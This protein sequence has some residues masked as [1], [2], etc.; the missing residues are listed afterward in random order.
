M[1]FKVFKFGGA[2]IKNA[3]AIK[4][5]ANIIQECANEKLMIVVSAMDKTTN[6]LE[7]VVDDAFYTNQDFTKK[8]DDI[9]NFHLQIIDDLINENKEETL[10]E[11]N[12][13]FNEL[14]LSCAYKHN[15]NYDKFYDQIVSFGELISTTIIYNY[16]KTRFNIYY[17]DARDFIITDAR[18]RDAAV[19]WEN[20]KLNVENNLI[21]KFEKYD[22]VISQGF[23][24]GNIDK[25]T[26]T[27]GR[28]GSDFSA[29]IFSY[30]L[31]AESLTVWK[32][33]D[34]LLNADPKYFENTEL[35]ENIS[36]RETIELA[37][38]GAKIIHPKTIQPLQNKSIPLYVKS[39]L[40]KNSKGSIINANERND[41]KIPSYIF[42]KN[43]VLI[44]ITPR[45]LSFVDESN[46]A[47]IFERLAYYSL[48][49]NL[50]QNSAI[51]FSIC[52]D[53]KEDKIAEFILDLS[54]EFEIRYNENLELITIRHYND[55]IIERMTKE[56]KIFLEQKS[57]ATVQYL[58]K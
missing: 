42:K 49:V 23:I 21:P 9:K 41:G 20:C 1:D 55:E 7:S 29:A 40:N 51:S 34:G 4:N 10:K 39:F 37:F 56:R 3:D 33:V 43:Q 14:S 48:K 27:L 45:N 38:Y 36:Y 22:F 24:G 54:D 35:I 19:I 31:D 15:N 13:L 11:V 44:S 50:M 12:G 5:M 2:S 32:D 47:I 30:L 26:T 57:R 53:N 52:L 16:L 46:L 18:Y 8:I 28:E 58:V 6:A 17:A 25:A